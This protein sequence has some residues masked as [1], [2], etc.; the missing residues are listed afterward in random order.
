MSGHA[1]AQ[2]D[3]FVLAAP[4]LDRAC[5]A[6]EATTGVRPAFGGAH[7]GRGTHNA[8]VAFDNGSYLEIIAPDP[9]QTPT[10]MSRPM[11]QL[12]RPTLMHWAVR[13]SGAAAL[14]ARLRALGW[15]PTEVRRMSRTPPNAATLEWELFGLP[16]HRHG[17]LVPF[18]IDWFACPHPAQTSP[19]VGALLTVRIAL[20]DPVP[21][22][23]LMA[24]LGIDHSVGVAVG[25]PELTIAFDT[26]HGAVTYS[27]RS[28]AGFTLD[29]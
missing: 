13:C 16:G 1:A 28:P 10:S 15:T 17:G 21:L 2:V 19:S 6:F 22:Q 4:D 8:L 24:E 11:A 23:T 3:H 18:F 25:E 27:G 12:P 5:D 26:R 14:G 9:A 29:R 20:P 7:A